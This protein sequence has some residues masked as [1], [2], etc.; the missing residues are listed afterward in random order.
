MTAQFISTATLRQIH[1]KCYLC[2]PD[3]EKFESLFCNI[4]RAFASFFCLQ[5]SSAFLLNPLS[6]CNSST[7]NEN[8]AKY[9]IFLSLFVL[10]HKHYN[11]VSLLAY[12]GRERESFK[13]SGEI[14]TYLHIYDIVLP[15]PY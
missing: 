13:S 4:D 7:T 2:F 14:T 6:V 10:F 9:T 3:A 15:H 12:L 5:V 1:R 8:K 11:E